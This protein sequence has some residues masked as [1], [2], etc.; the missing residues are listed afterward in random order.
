MVSRDRLLWV[1]L[2]LFTLFGVLIVRFYHLQI[3]QGEKWH[4]LAMSQHESLVIE[5][6]MR[7]A[8]YANLEVQPGH[9]GALHPIVVDVPHFHLFVD[10]DSI[11]EELKEKTACELKAALKGR[12][13]EARKL[14]AELGKKSRSRKVAMWLDRQE[15]DQILSWW[16]P[17]AVAQKLPKNALFFL[18][19]YRR[20]YPYG[21]MLGP[22]LHTVQELKDPKT[23]Q[24]LPTGGIELALNGVLQG[25]LGKRLI[26]HT[27]RH[28]IDV[29]TILET[30]ENG[31]DVFL[32]I[33]PYLQ[34]VAERELEAGV[35]AANGKMGWV[36]MMDPQNGEV[37]ALA[38]Y[39]PFHPAEYQKYFN[40]PKLLE[41]TRVRA[42]TDAFEPGS[43]MKPITAAICLQASVEQRQKG[44]NPIFSATEKI[45][46]SSGWFPG[47]S[48]PLKDGRTHS[49]LNLDLAMQKSSNVYMARITQRM[50]EA[51]GEA[52]YRR[53]LTE[54]FGL[55]Q[56][57]GLE[58][59]GESPG[60]VPTPGKLHPNGRLEWSVP[61]PYS[62]AIGHNILV[63][64]MQLVRA[65]AILA[66]GGRSVQ[67]HLV[68]KIVK[69]RGDGQ[70]EVLLD[71]TSM[72]LGKQL[73]SP[74][75]IAPV[76]RSM[77]FVTKEGGT[78]RR[79]DIPRYSEGG[80]SGTAEMIVGGTY[81]KE[82]YLSSFV[83]FAP[84]KNPRFVM[85]V[86]ILEPEV[87]IVPGVGKNY[88]GGTC[89]APIFREI[90]ARALPYLG[91]EPDDPHRTDWKAET[92]AL[93]KTYAEWN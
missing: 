91:V 70:A 55:G 46:T 75:V 9:R 13:E 61:T 56:K 77:R 22:V 14:R 74:E 86:S 23:H 6:F 15:R 80:K 39:P 34:A 93:K 68:R 12:T 48:K 20:S 33:N 26:V 90:G 62:L 60:I 73:L 85:L 3:I 17:Y 28:P 66:N 84:A 65:Y 64:S 16:N 88:H 19:D 67:P 32:T 49:F 40:D 44:K 52:W 41:L 79:G 63:N 54:V 37:L 18:P 76:M 69:T 24:A 10:P 50:V 11:P 45:P 71:R 72:P 83:G 5:P 31:A 81:S 92:E 42:V 87:K 8:I 1:A 59:P 89:A 25:K 38:Q 35:K 82:H 58:L 4:K 51:M 57:V 29:G 2:C 36:V 78:S 21:S 53:M 7:G 30:P 47:R 27:P 43:I